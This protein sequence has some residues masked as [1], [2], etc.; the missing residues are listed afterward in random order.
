MIST[1]M[2]L[3][4]WTVP[5]CPPPPSVR[6]LLALQGLLKSVP[7][8][9]ALGTI[10]A[11]VASPEHHTLPAVAAHLPHRLAGSVSQH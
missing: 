4:L 10:P 2:S 7:R 8:P 9:E 11:P 6:V 1:A 3:S 5:E